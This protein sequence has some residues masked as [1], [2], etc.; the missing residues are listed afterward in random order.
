MGRVERREEC[1][2]EVV[3]VVW[4]LEGLRKEEG[5]RDWRG[6]EDI[7][8]VSAVGGEV[9]QCLIELRCL[10]GYCDVSYARKGIKIKGCAWC[11]HGDHLKLRRKQTNA[12]QAAAK[13][14]FTIIGYSSSS[15]FL[16]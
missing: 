8:A 12:G 11:K 6:W 4:L 2:R 3:W 16:P 14:I 13:W 15:T 10:D 5:A 1:G 7:V 9:L